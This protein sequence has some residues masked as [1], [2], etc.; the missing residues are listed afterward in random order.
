[1]HNLFISV[2]KH[3]KEPSIRFAVQHYTPKQRIGAASSFRVAQP[4]YILLYNTRPTPIMLIYIY[5]GLN[6]RFK[7]SASADQFTTTSGVTGATAD[8]NTTGAMGLNVLL[9]GDGGQPFFDF[10]NQA[11][12]ANLV[13]VMILAPDLNLF[14][15]GGSGLQRTDGVAYSQAVN[16]LILN[17]LP[18]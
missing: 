18:T 16:D 9:H 10:P 14:W 7:V 17:E 6:L 11:V 2:Q 15:G 12:Q 1:M 3:R 8:P 5:S 4:T 13:G